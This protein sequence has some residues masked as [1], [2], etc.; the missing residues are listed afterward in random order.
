MAANEYSEGSVVYGKGDPLEYIS[1]IAEGEVEGSFGGHTFTLGKT[2]VIGLC[3]IIPGVY[4]HAY[5][6]ISNV[7]IYKYP[8]KDVRAL[9][10]LIRENSD[11]AYLMVSS[12]TRQVAELLHYRTSLM[13]ESKVAYDLLHDLYSEYSRLCKMYASTPRKLPGIEEINEFSGDDPVEDWVSNFYTEISELGSTAHKMFFHGN[14]GIESGFLRRCMDD[15]SRIF[16]ACTAYQDYL[17]EISK[18]LLHKG[19]YDLFSLIRQLHLDSMRIEGADFAV[20]TLMAPL[21]EALSDMTG[22]DPEFYQERLDAYWDALEEKRE[23]PDTSDAPAIQGLSHGLLD[24]LQTILEYSGCD[25]ELASNFARCVHAYTEFPDRNSTD[26]D[27][28]DTRRD[29][30]KL[31]YEVYKLVLINSL[32]DSTPP[33]AVNMFL[34]FGFV[35]ATLAGYENADYL[36]SIAD[37]FKGDPENNIFTVREW[38]TAIYQGAIEPSLSEFEMDFQAYVRDL[39][40]TKQID[41]AGERRLLADMNAKLLYEMDNAFPVVNRVTFGNPSKFCPVFADH[42]VQRNIEDTL[43]TAS[44][45]KEIL[46]EIRSIDFSA[47]YRETAFSN[48]NVTNETINVEVLPNIVLMP[49]VG[50]RGSMWQEIEGR[51][52]TTPARMFMPVFLENDLTTLMC[53]L[54]ADF[55]WEMCKRIQGARWN[56]LTDPSLTSFYCDY[57]QFYMNNRSIAMQT[58]NEIRNELSSARNNYKTV[59]SNNYLSWIQNEAKGQARLNSIV[60]G[61]FMTFMPFPASIRE[62]LSKNMRYNDAL[63]RYNV[64]RQRRVKRLTLLVRNLSKSPA[65]APKELKDELMFAQR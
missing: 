46:D 4:T 18:L 15:V 47:F 55:R 60:L 3:D 23:S 21:T 14:P 59:F 49:N 51:I 24:S 31:F 27:V 39:K 41:A 16:Q 9:E 7:S 44:K 36:Y 34:N 35:D 22:I 63:Q 25:D 65:G 58:M 29:L 57:L 56:D 50:I 1:L 26:D 40:N 2:D 42:N 62:T 6:A 38:L 12:M 53:R 32:E 17:G 13:H 8:C 19:G 54:T 20:E 43:V 33:T 61:I 48:K 11:F 30:T 5:T 64:K 28:Y 37:S 45:V 52:R 10:S